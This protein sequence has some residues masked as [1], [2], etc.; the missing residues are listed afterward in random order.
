MA[1]TNDER[2]KNKNIVLMSQV[3]FNW[4]SLLCM[5]VSTDNLNL[6]QDEVQEITS[7]GLPKAS[8][9]R[10]LCRVAS[11]CSC[12][13]LPSASYSWPLTLP[14]IL[15]LPWE[16]ALTTVIRTHWCPT[17]TTAMFQD[18]VS[19]LATRL[20]L[21]STADQS[22]VDKV[23]GSRFLQSIQTVSDNQFLHCWFHI[24]LV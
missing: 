9:I 1:I 18:N 4:L 5:L 3:N 7:P 13:T 20:G 16:P 15:M 11:H 14:L 6:N 2:Y 8:W 10:L 22:E 24:A 12:W 19:S 23:S 21:N 17:T